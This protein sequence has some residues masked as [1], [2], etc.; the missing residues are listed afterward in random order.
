MDECASY[1]CMNCGLCIDGIDVFEC[2]CQE[3]YTGTLCE[4][5]YIYHILPL[6]KKYHTY[7]I[8]I[9]KLNYLFL[10]YILDVFL[11]AYT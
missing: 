2:T 8:L 5:M 10:D 1:P 11:I 7:P 4:S 3:G 6:F 9:F